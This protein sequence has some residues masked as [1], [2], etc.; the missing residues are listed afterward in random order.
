MFSG[1][2]QMEPWLSLG[3]VKEN[4]NYSPIWRVFS[5]AI[6]YFEVDLVA[7]DNNFDKRCI[8]SLKHLSKIL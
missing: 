5:S 8:V 6:V 2:P 4:I 3:L 1:D 7:C